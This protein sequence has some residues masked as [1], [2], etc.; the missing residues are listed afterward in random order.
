MG[1]LKSFGVILKYGVRL[2]ILNLTDNKPVCLKPYPLPH[3]KVED[4]RKELKSMLELG[5]IDK[6]DYEYGSP[7][8]LIKMC[9][10]TFRFY[11]DY[12]KLNHVTEVCAETMPDLDPIFLP[13]FL[14]R[15]LYQNRLITWFLS[16]K[17]KGVRPSHISFC[18]TD[19][20]LH[21]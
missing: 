18:H 1:C 10:I 8:V 13:N 11:E 20:K 5:V 9:N 21:L 2:N 6:T 16:D 19:K 3:A 12:R 4:N 14:P 7:I 17:D 15:I